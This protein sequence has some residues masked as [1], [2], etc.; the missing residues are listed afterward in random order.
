[1]NPSTDLSESSF[2]EPSFHIVLHQPE[3]PPNTGTIGRTCVA[4]HAKLWLVRPL[5]FRT[6][7]KA[8]RRAGLDYWKYLN[9]QVVDEWTQLMH[10]ANA[11]ESGTE[12]VRMWMFTKTA[13]RDYR[14]S[15][16]KHGDWLVFGN[17]TSGLPP[18]LLTDSHQN[19]R[20]PTFDKVRSLNLA[21]AVAVA[22]YEAA[23]QIQL[24]DPE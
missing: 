13:S 21:S 2:Y 16:I 24:F 9:W 14:D 19:L 18:S 6:D 1:M 22:G 7:E 23:R 8:L 4:L 12:P 3:I 20:I 17:E 10:H 5:G 11:G 15:S